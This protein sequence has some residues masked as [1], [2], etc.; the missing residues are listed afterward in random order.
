MV[1]Y[2][3]LDSYKNFYLMIYFVFKG[4][5]SIFHIIQR[6]LFFI[7][8]QLWFSAYFFISDRK[9]IQQKARISTLV[10]QLYITCPRF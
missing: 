1:A 4:S 3:S 5:L 8:I 9:I 6:H 10:L 7:F 2:I